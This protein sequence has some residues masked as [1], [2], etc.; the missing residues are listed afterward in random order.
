MQWKCFT[1]VACGVLSVAVVGGGVGCG[2]CTV[3]G[4]DVRD[5]G[6]GVVEGVAAVVAAA[7]DVVAGVAVDVV[8]GVAAGV[9][10]TSKSRR[11][12][13]HV[14]SFFFFQLLFWVL[15]SLLRAG[16]LIGSINF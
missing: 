3:V 12:K 10:P 15:L 11:P 8:A 2:E 14:K 9:K 6:G 7:V 1:V 5:C 13:I 4:N 16:M